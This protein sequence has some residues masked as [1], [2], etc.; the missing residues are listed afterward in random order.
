MRTGKN[1][2]PTIISRSKAVKADMKIERMREAIISAYAGPAWRMR[3]MAMG[4]RQ[5]V[6]IYRDMQNKNRIGKK[7][8]ENAVKLKDDGVQLNIWDFLKDEG[9][10][11]K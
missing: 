4:D 9:E 8:R 7:P 6:A 1:G 10:S 3:V 5:V 11:E 2:A